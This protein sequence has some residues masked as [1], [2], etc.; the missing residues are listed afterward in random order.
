MK[1]YDP[2]KTFLELIK[3]YKG[4]LDEAYNQFEDAWSDAKN[5]DRTL[6]EAIGIDVNDLAK[7][8]LDEIDIP[9]LLKKYGKS[10][11]SAE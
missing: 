10:A 7:F 4:D 11:A 9:Y 2:Q 1:F 3:D 8:E 5:D 6:S